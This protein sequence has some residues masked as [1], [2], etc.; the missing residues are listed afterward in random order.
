MSALTASGRMLIVS[1]CHRV[2][3]AKVFD[4]S[5]SHM[6]V[7]FVFFSITDLVIR[8]G[9][10]V[11]V[12]CSVNDLFRSVREAAYAE[13]LTRTNALHPLP[14][15][16]AWSTC[17]DRVAFE[18]DLDLTADVA[19]YHSRAK[20]VTMLPLT[21]SKEEQAAFARHPL[22]RNNELTTGIH[23][24]MAAEIYSDV[25]D[26]IEEDSDSDSDVVTFG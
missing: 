5:V 23:K 6:T 26:E 15:L 4:E 18:V 11:E 19:L 9:V 16:R 20:V 13:A 8:D 21:L 2:A 22:F 25:L 10:V 1:G 14:I 3:A 17:K 12:V 7:K 24:D